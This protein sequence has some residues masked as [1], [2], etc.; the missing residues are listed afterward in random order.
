MIKRGDK[1]T[2]HRLNGI[3]SAIRRRIPS[4]VARHAQRLIVYPAPKVFPVGA[5]SGGVCVGSG[6]A[7]YYT[8]IFGTP[9]S[10]EGDGISPKIGSIDY[11]AIVVEGDVTASALTYVYLDATQVEHKQLIYSAPFS[12]TL[13]GNLFVN[14]RLNTPTGEIKISS[15]PPVNGG[16]TI[17]IID[18]SLNVRWHIGN[19]PFFR[20]APYKKSFETS[21]I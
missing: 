16:K 10:G 20:F 4:E 14:Y 3:E 8:Q 7:Y 21:P 11:E 1:L 15:T 13:M 6:R 9:P 18:S 2:A 5:Y 17:A 12:E 19:V